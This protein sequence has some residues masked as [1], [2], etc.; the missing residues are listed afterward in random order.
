MLKDDIVD[1]ALKRVEKSCKINHRARAWSRKEIEFFYD[2][3]PNVGKEAIKRMIPGLTD[4]MVYHMARLLNIKVKTE[5]A[6]KISMDRIHKRKR[7]FLNSEGMLK[8]VEDLSKMFICKIRCPEDLY[9][10]RYYGA[11]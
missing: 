5:V 4:N 7:V 11:R 10:K 6:K 1:S 2:R 8:E 9:G 3:Y